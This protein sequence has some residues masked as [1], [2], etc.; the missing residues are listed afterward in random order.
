M[1]PRF[2]APGAHVERTVVTLPSDE[3]HHLTNVLRLAVGDEVAV[4]DG[5]GHEWR[6]RVA[7]AGRRAATIELGPAVTPVPEPSVHV[8]LG[9]GILKSDQM[10]AVVRDATALL[11]IYQ[12]MSDF[13]ILNKTAVTTPPTTTSGHS[14][15][16]SGNT[17]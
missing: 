14:M 2:F 6:A 5:D 7:S 16:R 4:F 15:C 13:P 11:P 12:P 9:I 3:S 10:D 8:T 1:L 17:L